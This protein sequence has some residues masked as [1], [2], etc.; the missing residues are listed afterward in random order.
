MKRCSIIVPAV[1]LAFGLVPH[2]RAD[3]SSQALLRRLPPATN[4]IV[5]IDSKALRQALGSGNETA[6]AAMGLTGL[7]LMAGNFVLGAHIDYGEH[8]HL[9]SVAVFQVVGGMTIQ[10][11]AKSEKEPVQQLAGHAA[12]LSQRNVY[13]IDLG[14]GLMAAGMPANRQLLSRWL[15]FQDTNREDVLS[16]YLLKAANP[17]TPAMMTA[18]LD[19]G[20]ALD[21]AA[22]RRGLEHSEVLA[23]KSRERTDQSAQL[24]ATIKGLTFNVRA[25]NPL[26]GELTADFDG[27]TRHVATFE[28]ELL[29]E[30]LRYTGLY[31]EDFDGWQEPPWK[32][33]T[34]TIH[35]PLSANGLRKV[36]MLIKTPV[37]SPD[38]AAGNASSLPADPVARALVASQRYFKSVTQILAD[39]KADKGKNQ[40]SRAGWYDQAADQMSALPTLDVAPEL[41]G[42]GQGT[43]DQL[44]AMA[45]GQKDLT[46]KVTYVRRNSY[47]SAYG[48]VYGNAQMG[49]LVPTQKVIESLEGQATQARRETWERIDQATAQLR[50]QMTQKFNVQF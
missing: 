39:L 4:A 10:D 32:D 37:P 27:E 44:R 41:V 26:E 11:V 12:V 21:P 36:G 38:A 14:D 40:N 31:L 20:N 1:A 8:R 3:G 47:Q 50:T 18:A 16:P 24:I 48:W 9:W 46:T 5:V 19:L 34:V 35:G 25:G 6:A 42:Y 28:R 45:A 33:R 49:N 30:A 2:A 7:P 22:I 43:A 13:F 17:E 29:L 15:Q 23:T